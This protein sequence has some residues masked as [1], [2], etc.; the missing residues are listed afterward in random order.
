MSSR[1]GCDPR[2]VQDLP[3]PLPHAPASQGFPRRRAPGGAQPGGPRAPRAAGRRT[4][5]PARAARC[6]GIGRAAAGAARRLGLEHPVLW[7][8]LPTYLRTADALDPRLVVY[9][10]VDRYAGNPGVDAAWVD[11][12]E[13]RMLR[14]ADLVFASSPALAEWL[15][16]ERPDVEL[17]ANASGRRALRARGDGGASRALRA[18]R[19]SPRRAPSTSETSPP[20]GSTSSSSWRWPAP[21]RSSSSS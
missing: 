18:P 10:C 15:G 5:R 9:H 11:E 1:R 6:G 16:A 7:A 12:L 20:T 14:R 8:F 13:R 19:R 3:R 17:F 2:P 4:P 21:A